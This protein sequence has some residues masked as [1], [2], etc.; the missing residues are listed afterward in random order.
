MKKAIRQIG[1]CAVILI[2]VLSIIGT[3]GYFSYALAAST[4]DDI[5]KRGTLRFGWAI[6]WPY[7]YRDAKTNQLV[8]IGADLAEEMAKALNVK[9]EWVEDTWISF[10]GALQANKFDCFSLCSITLQRAVACGFSQ[11]VT[12]HTMSFIVKKAS[13]PRAKSWQDM[14]KKGKKLAITFG[15]VADTYISRPGLVKDAEIVRLKTSP[16]AF[17]SMMTG[18]TNAY[19]GTVDSLTALAKDNPGTYILDG[20]YGR[21]YVAL[22]LRQDDQPW[23]NWVNLFVR[24]M[25]AT[26]TIKKLLSKYGMAA[27]FAVD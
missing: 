15:S 16:E 25:K 10:P 27:S 5:Q 19:G 2:L 20:S 17:S 4:L 18:K 1:N 24:E 11:P 6:W 14:D 12:A 13:E 23:I 8:G 3:G 21:A 9:L 26:G 22:A 7:I